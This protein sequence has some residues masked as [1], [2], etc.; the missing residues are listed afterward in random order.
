MRPCPPV[1]VGIVLVV[2]DGLAAQVHDRLCRRALLPGPLQLRTEPTAGHCTERDHQQQCGTAE[3]KPA[4][5]GPRGSSHVPSIGQTPRTVNANLKD[6]KTGAKLHAM[7]PDVG[8]G[9]S[10]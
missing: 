5:F 2:V 9:R 8:Q 3:L 6:Q 4:E 7:L 1:G 10:T